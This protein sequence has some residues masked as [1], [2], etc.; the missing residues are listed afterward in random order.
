MIVTFEK[1]FSK[2][3]DKINNKLILKKIE[4]AIVNCE[5]SNKLSEIKYLKKL[6]GHKTYYR[7]KLNDYRVGVEIIN[8]EI[9]FIIACHRK[10]IYKL[11]P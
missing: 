7:I 8:N 9:N 5:N 1:S 11:F 6:K 3:L 4:E 2:S 10:D